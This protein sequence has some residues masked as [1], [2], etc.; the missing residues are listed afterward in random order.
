MCVCVCVKWSG[1]VLA[2]SK[3]YVHIN[4]HLWI[5]FIMATAPNMRDLTE[6]ATV[7]STLQ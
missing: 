3:V 1:K 2:A 7:V 6:L 5:L 4:A